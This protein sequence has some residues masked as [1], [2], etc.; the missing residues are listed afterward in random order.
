MSRRDCYERT[1]DLAVLAN[2]ST[3]DRP[4]DRPN[5]P[6]ADEAVFLCDTTPI[7]VLI[8]KSTTQSGYLILTIFDG[9][10]VTTECVCECPCGAVTL[11]TS[12]VLG[13]NVRVYILT[14]IVASGLTGHDGT[15]PVLTIKSVTIRP[16]LE[17][18]PHCLDFSCDC[19][20]FR[21][22]DIGDFVPCAIIGKRLK[23]VETADEGG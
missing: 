12:A 20:K 17:N 2:H 16:L 4:L 3:E 9:G 23:F 15:P 8:A 6:N 11:E 21:V 18:I 19:T 7:G 10:V 5:P 22:D 14:L 1:I 13:A